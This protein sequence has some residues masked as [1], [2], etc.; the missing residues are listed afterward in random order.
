MK[1]NCGGLNRKSNPIYTLRL[2][3]DKKGEKEKEKE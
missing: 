3:N 1:I 2:Q